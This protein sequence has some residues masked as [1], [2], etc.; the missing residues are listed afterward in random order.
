MKPRIKLAESII[1]NGT[2]MA[3][4]EHD[5]AF[6]VSLN[7]KELM[8]SKVT[9][10]ESLLGRIGVD[11]I[12]K[13]ISSRVLIGG[14]GLGFTLKSVLDSGSL[15]MK[16]VLAELFSEVIEWNRTYLKSLNGMLLDE[17]CVNI[18]SENV[19]ELIK[20]TE[21]RIY[22]AILLDVDNGPVA[23]VDENNDQLYSTSGIRL[24]CRAL[25]KG[26][27][28]SIWSAGLDLKFENRLT[29]LG[30]KFLSVPAKAYN[31]A[32]RSRNVIYVI[33]PNCLL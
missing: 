26:G 23:M 6:S 22:D 13:D 17:P 7:G 18:K 1:H 33:D 27:R 8:H 11:H 28:I 5:G 10:S 12:N 2:R 30:C 14:L 24:M 15:K 29:K 19:I 9:A 32:K 21:P 25:K 4:Y 3:L 31:G 20:K 16:I